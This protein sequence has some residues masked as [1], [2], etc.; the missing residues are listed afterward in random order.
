MLRTTALTL[1]VG[2]LVAADRPNEAGRGGDIEGT[3]QATAGTDHGKKAPAS[4]AK[5]MSITFKGGN[6][7]VK[8]GGRTV[9]TGTYKVDA[10]KKPS[11]IDRTTNEGPDKGKAMLGIYE[12]KGDTLKTAFEEP[13][14][15]RPTTFDGQKSELTEFTRSKQ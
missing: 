5:S 1:A 6:Y 8:V 2:V 11:E 7:V 15:P 3:W 10:S 9:A 14:K 12:V 13:G 4:E